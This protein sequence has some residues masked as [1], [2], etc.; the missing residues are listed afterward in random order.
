MALPA[1]EVLGRKAALFKIRLPGPPLTA[2]QVAGIRGA[3]RHP[4]PA[5]GPLIRFRLV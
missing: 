5:G 3:T 4:A 1:Q 2:A